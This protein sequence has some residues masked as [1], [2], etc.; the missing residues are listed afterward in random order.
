MA[1]RVVNYG[2][3]VRHLIR[4]EMQRRLKACAILVVNHA[5]ELINI[6]G[7]G[8][9]IRKYSYHYAGRRRDAKKK[10]I[11]Y[12]YV[13]SE[14]GEPPRK[15]F[16]RLLASVAWELLEAD[17][18]ARVGTNVKYGRFLELGTSKMAARPW[19]RRA[20]REKEAEIQAILSAPLN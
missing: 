4:K 8:R 18:K 11:I 17:M 2:D 9:A 14:P 19:L 7:T 10:G 5:K 3:Q 12:G 15:Q 1:I 16:G 6:D 20:L 13:V